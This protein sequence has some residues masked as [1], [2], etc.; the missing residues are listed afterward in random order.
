MKNNPIII[1]GAVRSGTKIVRDSICSVEGFETWP[2]YEINY[3]WRHGNIQKK[4]DRIVAD[5]VTT[6]VKKFIKNQFKKL[7]KEFG[8]EFVVEKTCANSLNIPF[9]NEI[10]PD[11]KYIFIAREGHDVASSA[12]QRWTASLEM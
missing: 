5:D 11:A 4:T 3:I 10:F 6:E 1:I 8:P 12:K 7:E 9:I 2:C